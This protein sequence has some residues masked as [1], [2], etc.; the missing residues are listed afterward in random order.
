MCKAQWY[1]QKIHVL[2][3]LCHSHTL[4]PRACNSLCPYFKQEILHSIFR[5]YL[6]NFLLSAAFSS[7]QSQDHFPAEIPARQLL[8]VMMWRINLNFSE[9]EKGIFQADVYSKVFP[10]ASYWKRI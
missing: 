9:W 6:K 1:I 8:H 4:Q 2:L 10:I 3:L 7:L 5:W